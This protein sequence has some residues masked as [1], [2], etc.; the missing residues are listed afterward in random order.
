MYLADTNLLLTIAGI[1][2]ND[3]INKKALFEFLSKEEIAISVVSIFEILNNPNFKDHYSFIVH[4]VI[5]KCRKTSFLSSAFYNIYFDASILTDLENKNINE[6]EKIK[7][8]ISKPFVDIYSYYY[9]NLIACAVMAYFIIFANFPDSDFNDENFFKDIIQGSFDILE[10]K[11]YQYLVYQFTNMTRNYWFTE[12][13][14]KHLV[15]KI[16]FGLITK[17]YSRVYNDTYLELEKNNSIKYV[18]LLHKLKSVS[19]KIKIENVISINEHIKFQDVSLY[20]SLSAL[21][22]FEDKERMKTYIF[23][24]ATT[25]SKNDVIRISPYLNKLFE[26][27]LKSLLFEKARFNDNDI[28]DSLVLDFAC[29]FEKTINFKGFITFDKKLTNKSK[30]VYPSLKLIEESFFEKRLH[31]I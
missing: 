9:S 20:N 29:F 19:R 24:I 18:K 27:N 17:V 28:F 26:S 13:N 3:N 14:R 2:S 10:P 23:E 11:I 16:F 22:D 1:D 6:Q 30:I 7:S 25:L 12:K 15:E 21:I 31:N 8:I 5:E 4:S